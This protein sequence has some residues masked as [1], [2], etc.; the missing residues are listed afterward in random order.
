[1]LQL[2]RF[3]R[4]YPGLYRQAQ[5]PTSDGVIPVRLFW[6]LMQARPAVMAEERLQMNRAV[7]L[8]IARAMSEDPKVAATERAERREAFPED[9]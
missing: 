3:T 7:G 6:G 8:A 2:A 1:M 9:R 4:W 5:Y